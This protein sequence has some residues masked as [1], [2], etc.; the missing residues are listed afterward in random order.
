MFRVFLVSCLHNRPRPVEII[1]PE[2]I[3]EVYRLLEW[4]KENLQSDKNYDLVLQ[5]AFTRLCDVSV[6]SV[7]N[8]NIQSYAAI[9]LD[10]MKGIF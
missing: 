1:Y 9:V 6:P 10:A 7:K 4:I 5:Y 2:G 8:G 3:E